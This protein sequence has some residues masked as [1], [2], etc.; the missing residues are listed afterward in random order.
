MYWSGWRG[1]KIR[2][3]NLDGS[4]IEIIVSEVDRVRDFEVD[5]S[6]GKLY[7]ASDRGVL[8]ANLDGSQVETLFTENS[9]GL[10]LDLGAGKIYWTEWVVYE[11]VRRANLD[12]SQIETLVSVSGWPKDIA[13]GP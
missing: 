6:E 10:A 7:W 4:Q 2:R 8:R 1:D 3:A 13:L 9:M 12:G 11:R 5:E